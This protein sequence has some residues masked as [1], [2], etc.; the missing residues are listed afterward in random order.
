MWAQSYLISLLGGVHPRWWNNKQVSALA[1]IS[2]S[3]NI[4]IVVMII[5]INILIL[6]V[7]L[8]KISMN[9]VPEKVAHIRQGS[10]SYFMDRRIGEGGIEVMHAMEKPTLLP[11]NKS[12]GMEA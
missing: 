9:I 7:E 11:L 1:P 3:I 5:N 10:F 2:I 6:E 12:S 4:D 8:L